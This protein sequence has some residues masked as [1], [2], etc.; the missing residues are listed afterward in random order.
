MRTDGALPAS[1]SSRRYIGEDALAGPASAELLGLAPL[2]DLC[3]P[4]DRFHSVFSRIHVLR[5][6]TRIHAETLRATAP[7]DAFTALLAGRPD[8]AGW[9]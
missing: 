4:R 5:L 8:P 1:S 3:S 9:G 6:H 2:H 7:F